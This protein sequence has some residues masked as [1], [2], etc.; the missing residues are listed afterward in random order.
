M[1]GLEITPALIAGLFLKDLRQVVIDSHGL[2]IALSSLV[3]LGAVLRLIFGKDS[4]PADL[5][6]QI[7]GLTG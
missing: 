7:K 2:L 6:S 1:M 3:T 4:R 5:R